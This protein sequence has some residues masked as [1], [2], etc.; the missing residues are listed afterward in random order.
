MASI[1]FLLV[2]TCGGR[3]RL[4]RHT[5]TTSTEY[6]SALQRRAI[7]ACVGRPHGEVCDVTVQPCLQWV[8]CSFVDI[9]SELRAVYRTYASLMFIVGVS[10][11]EV[12]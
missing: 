8:Q 1:Q 12:G 2:A 7:E 9:D 5:T 6:R 11:R 10:P 4:A 3:T